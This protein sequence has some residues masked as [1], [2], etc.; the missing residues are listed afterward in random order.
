[1]KQKN[2]FSGQIGF[3]FAAAG[4]AVGVGNLWR[5]PYLAAKDGGGLF[6]IIYLVLVLTVGF[7]LLTTDI[8]IGRKTGKSAIYAYES[9]RKKWKFLGV[10]TFLVPVLIMTYYA[11]IGGW[12]LRYIVIYLTSSGKQ[13]VADNCFTAFISS[14]S[15]VWYGLI[16]MLLTALIVYNGV[17]DG[18]ERVSKFIMPVLLIM[19][20]GIA[21]FSLTL[22]TTLD[23]G[24]VRTGLQGLKVYMKPDLTGITVGRFLQITL[25]AMSQLFFS[26]SVSM[27]IM[28]TYGSYVKN[29]IDLNKATNQ[30]EIFDTGV[31][32]LAGMMI[33]PA[34]FVFLG[35]DGMASGPSLI[36]ISLPKVFDAM[37]VFGR[38]AAIAFFLMMGFAAL[39][40]CVSVME[41][42]VA[43]GMELYHKPRKKMCGVVGIYS[44]ITAVLICL[45]YN[46]LYFELKLPNG[47]V[48]QLLDVMDYI[49]NSFLMPFISLLTSILI[50]WVIGPD[51]II[52]EVERNG[53]KFKRAGMYRFMIRYVV[54]VVMLVLFLVS[55]GFADL[56]A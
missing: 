30:I 38:P 33:I 1:M 17:E 2:S 47:S 15:S 37:G 21:I 9:M 29:D 53:E 28:I 42:L 46:K 32:I 48:G 56:I 20:I 24:T 3:V 50:G 26:L 44:F 14:P 6:L 35:N 54:P 34:V 12:I 36:F 4:S 19:V 5:F 13:A 31:A 45:G 18:I 23:D 49:S 41:T 51:W 10:I 11:V 22:K 16:F 55:T 27:G 25:D 40:S 8:A 39:T 52:G 7:V 43:N